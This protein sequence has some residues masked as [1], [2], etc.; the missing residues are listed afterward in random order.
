M[1]MAL[2]SFLDGADYPARFSELREGFRAE[3]QRA[4]PWMAAG[5]AGIGLWRLENQDGRLALVRYPPPAVATSYIYHALL[6]TTDSGWRVHAL[7][8]EREAGPQ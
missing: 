7:E 4:A 6:R 8:Q 3:L 5:S 2:L 1:K